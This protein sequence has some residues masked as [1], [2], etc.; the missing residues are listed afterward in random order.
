MTN[1]PQP[2]SSTSIRR[3]QSAQLV[4]LM[5]SKKNNQRAANLLPHVMPMLM[6]HIAKAAVA[7]LGNNGDGAA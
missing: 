4:A 1:T 7:Q 2:I 3:A 6:G 5:E